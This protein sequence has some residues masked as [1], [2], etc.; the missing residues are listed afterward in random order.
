M[1]GKK[2]KAYQWGYNMRKK[3][4]EKIMEARVQGKSIGLVQ[5]S[6]DLFHIGHLR[7]LKKAR[8]LCD[9]LV[10]AMD[11]DEKIKK[12]KG[13]TRP[14]IPEKERYD[15]IKL[16][17]IADLIV[18]KPVREPKWNLIKTIEPDVLVA[19]KENYN[20]EEIKELEN[21][22]RQVAIL[23]RQSE[24]STSDKIRKIMISSTGRLMK[25][26][27]QKVMEAI[28]SLKERINYTDDMPEPIPELINYLP[29]STDFSVPV[30]ACCQV[31][32]TYVFGANQTDF[33]IPE[34]DIENR[35][36]LY[37]ATVE[38]AEIN[39]LKKMG[40]IDKITSPVYTTLF[41]C[42]KCMKVLIEKG[43]KEIY[44]LEDHPKRNWSKK[45]HVLARQNGVKTECLLDNKKEMEIVDDVDKY[46]YIYP[47]NARKQEQLDIMINMEN[48]GKDPL[49]PQYI[50]QEILF[51]TN[52]WFVS[53]NRFPYD[54]V[55][56][57]FLIVSRY[58]IY[59]KEDMNDSM[60]IDLQNIWN[61]LTK[62][63]NLPGGALCFRFGEPA[64]SGASLKRLHCHLII[65]KENLKTK[66]TI[67]GKKELKRG[68]TINNNNNK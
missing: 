34:K 63:Y 7:Y 16:L 27:E 58:P 62:G 57:Q 32:D 3:D 49:N 36:E 19:I 67:G 30:A 25:Q 10:V 40:S 65:P 1:L 13:E 55:E 18:I 48:D 11:S 22:C 61:E 28:A 5:G 68:L 26:N 2:L 20:E 66:F 53:Q 45:S 59:R 37:Y 54:D 24:T 44:Y 46:K 4:F 6:W 8:G 14:I 29:N 17:N 15:F 23:P 12:R 60:W 38:H 9:F 35:T 43:V 50:N 31:N 47:P 21:Y 41:P 33:K 52:Y 42:D 56:A 51:M 39:M 64:Y